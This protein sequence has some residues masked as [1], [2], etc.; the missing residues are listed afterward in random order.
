MFV[1]FTKI[2]LFLKSMFKIFSFKPKTE[3]LDEETTSETYEFMN[4]HNLEILENIERI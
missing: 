3:E 2:N 1:I 4:F